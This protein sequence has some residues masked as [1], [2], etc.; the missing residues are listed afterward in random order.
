MSDRE[1]PFPGDWCNLVKEDFEKISV[2]MTDVQ[3]ENMPE[4]DYKRHIKKKTRKAAFVFLQSIKENHDK[5][6]TNVYDNFKKIRK[7]ISQEKSL[8]I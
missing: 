7:T 5:V 4:S 1:S 3:I 8:L 6:K 2:H